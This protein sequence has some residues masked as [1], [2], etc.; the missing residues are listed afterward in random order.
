MKVDLRDHRLKKLSWV[1]VIK[2]E[3]N[4]MSKCDFCNI[5]QTILFYSIGISCVCYKC[6][7]QVVL[8]ECYLIYITFIR[9]LPQDL[10]T[11]LCDLFMR[12]VLIVPIIMDCTYVIESKIEF[13]ES[14][15]V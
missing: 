12:L 10:I 15:Y 14:Q 9:Y 7:K 5:S 8:R 1:D 2:A 3:L 11:V 6:L 4:A 13:T